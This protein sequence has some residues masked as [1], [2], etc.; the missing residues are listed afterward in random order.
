MEKENNALQ[1][2]LA[3]RYLTAK[4]AL[5]ERAYHTLNPRQQ[6]A[7]F[8]VNGPL[9]VLAGAGSGKTTVL[10]RRIAFIIRYGNAYHSTRVPR[11]ITEE[12][13]CQLEHAAQTLPPQEILPLLDA[14]AEPTCRPYQMLGITFTNKAANEIKSRLSN[15]FPEQPEYAQ[16]ICTGTFHSVCV[17]ILRRFGDRVG[18]RSGFS[19]Y[20]ADDA[21]RALSEAMK[22]ANVDE[23]VYPLK[24]VGSV[25][26]R[27]KDRLTTPEELEAESGNDP[28]LLRIARVYM[29]YQQYLRESNAVDFDDIIMQTVLLLRNHRD[30]LEHYQNRFRYVCVDE[31]QDTNPAQFALTDLLAGGSGN[32][33]VVGDDDQS[34]YKFRG[35]TIENI[36]TFHKHY[37]STRVIRLE[38]NY[39][40]TQNILDAANAVI[41]CN[42]GRMGKELWTSRGA[43]SRI[44]LIECEDQNAESR[45]MVEIIQRLVARG[46]ASYRDIAILYRMNAQSQS[47]EK[48]FARAA[49]PYRMLGGLRF[50]DRKEIRDI[51]AYLQLIVNPHD[52]TRL[53]RIINEPKRKIGAK[54]LEA[55]AILAEE[56][57]CSQFEI[58][59]NASRFAALKNACP[60]LEKF[61]DLIHAVTEDEK[62]MSIDA[63][64][65]SVLDRSG[66]RQMLV[67]AGEAE[68][69]R[70]Q[71]LEEFKSQILD[72]QK[73]AENPTL[74][75][76][77]EETALVAEVDRY[78]ESADAVVMM[79]IHSAKGL[80]FP[81]VFLPGMEDGIF[82]GMQSIEA[83]A[84]ELE[85]ERRLAYVAITRAKSELYILRTFQRLLFGR[86]CYNPVSRFVSEIPEAL[87]EKESKRRDT[88]YFGSIYGQGTPGG[89]YGSRG[90]SPS[91]KTQRT[92]YSDRYPTDTTEVKRK[93]PTPPPSEQ[94]RAGDRVRHMVFGV[95]E[96]LSVKPM[97]T[98]VLY[99]VMFERAGTKKLM[100]TYAKLKKE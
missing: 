23:K 70:L 74:A 72:Y 13:I 92:Y 93:K 20:D 4:Q 2:R 73:E 25:I 50:T 22:R 56:Q 85:E 37:Q 98:D 88:G 33:M 5:F 97:G 89:T 90:A 10:V 54:T 65:E 42:R 39:R 34:I 21:K 87:L 43:G 14:F 30:V 57:G 64:F 55:V 46:E 9:L 26:S 68:A 100:A 51:V 80:E 66:Y 53:A 29:Q 16:E 95:G 75:G 31:Y 67:D 40:S 71:N 91:P 60:M 61:A 49:I 7:V 48:A 38:Q 24:M 47:M 8:H 45:R 82:P 84:E 44:R 83:G 36:L 15:M 69:E 99:E 81:I 27:A 28:K 1:Q 11:G 58:I 17:R 59:E 86:T 76:F 77:L 62:R 12:Q 52:N 41:K 79:T 78:D 3:D 32:L 19:I 35:A 94:F 96:I 6:E 63:L 18:Y